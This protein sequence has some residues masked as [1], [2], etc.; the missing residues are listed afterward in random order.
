MFCNLLWGYMIKPQEFTCNWQPNVWLQLLYC[1]NYVKNKVNRSK[2]RT[3]FI[4]YVKSYKNKIECLGK[5]F[6][7]TCIYMFLTEPSKKQLVWISKN[8]IMHCLYYFT[9]LGK[10][11]VCNKIKFC[12]WWWGTFSQTY[13]TVI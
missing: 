2:G 9:Y 13:G 3:L 5:N 1:R 12:F 6:L 8:K 10:M 4:V 11:S 7:I